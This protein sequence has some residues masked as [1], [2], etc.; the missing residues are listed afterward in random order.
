MRF[1]TEAERVLKRAE[2]LALFAILDDQ[3]RH[4]REGKDGRVEF[5]RRLFDDAFPP[6][7][8]EKVRCCLYPNYYPD[9]RPLIQS[10]PCSTSEQ[11][12]E[13]GRMPRTIPG[14]F[15]PDGAE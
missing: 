1:E 8:P 5:E 3:T 4:S 7:K 6:V 10:V 11:F 15:V 12:V 14:T 2:Y 9:G 13:L